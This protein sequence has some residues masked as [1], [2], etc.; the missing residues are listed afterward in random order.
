[1]R[2][3]IIAIGAALVVANGWALIRQ[4]VMPAAPEELRATRSSAAS[5]RRKREVAE[6]AGRRADGSLV[7]APTA[8]TIAFLVLGVLLIIWGVG[9]LVSGG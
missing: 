9:S 5:Q 8:R 1:M 3:L 2:E 6:R 4:R 7:V